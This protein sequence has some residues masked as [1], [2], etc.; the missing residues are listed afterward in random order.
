MT[1]LREE[2][3]VNWSISINKQ[4]NTKS[5]SQEPLLINPIQTVGIQFFL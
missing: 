3:L 2:R 1:R 4:H 5:R